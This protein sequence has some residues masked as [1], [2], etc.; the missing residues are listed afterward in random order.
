MQLS[1][2]AKSL[3]G[4]V[5]LVSVLVYLVV[6][7]LGVSAGR[8]HHGVE[9]R[10]GLDLGGL[11]VAEAA[12]RLEERQELMLS[13][14]IVMGGEGIIVRFYPRVPIGAPKG[15]LGA[16]WRPK[17]ADTAQEAFDVGRRDAPIGA[18]LDRIDAW[19][20]GA[21]V[22]WQGSPKAIKVDRILEAVEEMAEPEGLT[23]DRPS[24]RLKIRRI[25]N[26]WPRR[27]FYRIPFL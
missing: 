15:T 22:T 16:G 18:L 17:R 11:T 19:L 7:D 10:E 6:V 24:M 2:L 4:V 3:L 14:E 13:D 25:L 23:L 5:A 27:P 26:R 12:A 20:G 21:E 9:I 1:G 8:I